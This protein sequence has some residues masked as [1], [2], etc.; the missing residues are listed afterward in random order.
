MSYIDFH[1]EKRSDAERHRW[2]PTLDRWNQ[3]NNYCFR[4]KIGEFFFVK[5][6]EEDFSFLLSKTAKIFSFG[7]TTLLENATKNE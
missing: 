6:I 3:K 5:E 7:Q 1:F 4:Q 2:I